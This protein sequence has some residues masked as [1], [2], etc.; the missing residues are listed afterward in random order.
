MNIRSILRL[1]LALG[2]LFPLGLTAS[3][4][5]AAQQLAD[6]ALPH[7]L[8]SDGRIRQALAYC[9]DR[10]ALIDSVYPGLG[11]AE[12]SSLLMDTYLSKE[13][14]AYSAP[15]PEHAYPFD[16]AQGGQLLEDAGWILQ[17]GATYRT[18]ADGYELAVSLTTTTATFRVT[19]SSVLE[20]QLRENCGIRLVRRHIPAS[21]L[22]GD[23]T[24]LQ[25]RDFET[26][27]Y[28]WIVSSNPAPASL[29]SCDQIPT[30]DNGWIG[31]N[32]MGWCNPIADQAV[33]DAHL[34]WTRADILEQATILQ[35]EFAK[36]MVSL[37]VFHRIETYAADARLAQFSPSPSEQMYL[38]N[39][40]LWSIPGEDTLRIGSTQEPASLFPA[41]ESSYISTLVSAAVYGQ[42]ATHLNYDLQ[43]Q[44]YTAVPTVENGGIL[45]QTVAVSQG[46]RV[47]DA[48]GT[49]VDLQPGMQVIDV[50]G[51]LITYTSGTV[52]MVQVSF[53]I[54]YL[55]GA[56]WSDG[57]SL[58][59][60]DLR[61]WDE[62]NCYYNPATCENIAERAYLG[63]TG[64]RYTMLPGYRDVLNPPLP[65]AYPANRQLSDGR[66]LKQVPFADWGSLPEIA[67]KPIGLGPYYVDA[68]Q[69]GEYIRLARN[70]YYALGQPLTPYLE[71]VFRE[72]EGLQ[73]MLAARTIHVLDSSTLYGVSFTPA[74][75]S[76][77]S[78]G[79]VD[80]YLLPSVT[81]EHVD[82]NLELYSQLSAL[83][84]GTAGGVLT[85]TLGI[86]VDIPESAFN[87]EVTL[88]LQNTYLPLQPLPGSVPM[89]SFSLEALD[90]AGQPVTTLAE[91]LTLTIIYA[92][93]Q[94]AAA[95]LDEADLNLAYWN[96]FAWEFLLPCAGCSHDLEANQVIVV[97]DHLSEFSL[98]AVQEKLFLP[99]IQHQ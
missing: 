9:T 83:P 92:D 60:E 29:Y 59:Q 74:L 82:F 97:L 67:Q 95:G 68:W 7:P 41:T 25:R 73:D 86:T 46:D 27:V 88:L 47:L 69:Q 39:A 15:P 12:K 77:I 21:V 58:S 89:L 94:I 76:A 10:Q 23:D 55:D 34:A 80:R 38:W 42:A 72:Y 22:F 8:L 99:L 20:K 33:K 51:Q 1:L 3:G 14:W 43:A 49:P 11:L 40:H 2:L 36:D 91:P 35:N 31:Q 70:P 61:L 44:L 50:H 54:H 65:G 17:P 90:A 64:V 19:W 79:L 66:L 98:A 96:G 71:I 75:Q 37:P 45:T 30:P 4:A 85:N 52:E 81:W 18:N 78:A 16:P 57:S 56:K 32:Y 93:E 87:Q 28:A 53:T 26:S 84:I 24:G 13:H 63:E 48:V 5:S 6:A 62:V